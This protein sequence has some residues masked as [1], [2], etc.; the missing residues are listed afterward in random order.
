MA[1]EDG[2]IERRLQVAAAAGSV[3]A[4][5]FPP[6]LRASLPFAYANSLRILGLLWDCRLCSTDHISGLLSRANIRHG[7]T[8]RLARSAWG[9]ETGVL[10]S[11]DAAFLT[12][13]SGYGLATVGSGAY[14]TK[15]VRRANLPTSLH[16]ALLG[17][18]G[19]RA[20]LP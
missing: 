7:V 3:P 10:R 9:L 12:S 18:A 4:K 17:S 5:V 13:L 20:W 16:T 6:G 14:E 1:R 2:L 11:T 8:A 19:L 15:L